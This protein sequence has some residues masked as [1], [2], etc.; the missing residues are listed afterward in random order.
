MSDSATEKATQILGFIKPDKEKS[1]G[2]IEW[3]NNKLCFPIAISVDNLNHKESARRKEIRSDLNKIKQSKLRFLVYGVSLAHISFWIKPERFK[4]ALIFFSLWGT[5]DH[6]FSGQKKFS[7]VINS[8]IYNK[9]LTQRAPLSLVCKIMVRNFWKMFQRCK[10]MLNIFSYFSNELFHL[11]PLSKRY[12]E[13]Y[14]EP[15]Q[16][17]EMECFATIVNGLTPLPIFAVNFIL[18]VW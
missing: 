7:L 8:V 4:R 10:K 11:F 2:N 3:V 16:I 14:S 17:S 13:A 5:T 12:P 18:D 6:G 9:S 1:C 15:C